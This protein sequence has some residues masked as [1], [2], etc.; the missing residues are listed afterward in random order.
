MQIADYYSVQA[1]ELLYTN[2]Q[3]KYRRHEMNHAAGRHIVLKLITSNDL[4]QTG[5][6]PFQPVPSSWQVLTSEP[7]RTYP[8]LHVYVTVRRSA[9]SVT[10]P[11]A[12]DGGDTQTEDIQEISMKFKLKLN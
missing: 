7:T 9:D 3:R 2:N 4:P 10:S 1:N 5:D 12:T 8:T 6:T 11:L